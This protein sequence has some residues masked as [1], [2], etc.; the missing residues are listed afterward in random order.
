MVIT[1][2]VPVQLGA[3][4]DDGASQ[5]LTE[6]PQP[7]DQGMDRP[8]G[9]PGDIVGVDL[10]AAHHQQ[11]R[12][13]AGQVLLRQQPVDAQ[14]AVGRRVMGFAAGTMQQLLDARMQDEV[15]RSR[16]AVQQMRRP[17]GDARAVID[18][19]VVLD[20][21]IAGQGGVQRHIDQVHKRMGTHRNDR[22]LP[23]IEANSA[24]ALQAQR[25]LQ[26]PRTHQPQH[27]PRRFQAPQQRA[28]QHRW[29]RLRVFRQWQ[30]IGHPGAGLLGNR[31]AMITQVGAAAL[32]Y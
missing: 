2:G 19:Q 32:V 12:T 22:A 24:H 31:A 3:V 13:L 10:V 11:R 27:Q 18:Q 25:Q 21:L 16:I 23:G 17:G 7:F 1:G 4:A 9:R 5:M 6:K 30:S 20:H 8:Q 14:Q 28:R 29:Q 15:R 26:R